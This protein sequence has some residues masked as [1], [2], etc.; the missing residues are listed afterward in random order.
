MAEPGEDALRI[1]QEMHDSYERQAPVFGAMPPGTQS[2]P[3]VVMPESYRQVMVA[4]A[5]DLM[6]RKV[7]AVGHSH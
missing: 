1:A 3:W 4:V 6:E 7:I 2:R 5:S